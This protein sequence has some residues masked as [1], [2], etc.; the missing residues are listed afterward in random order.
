MPVDLCRAQLGYN[1]TFSFHCCCR[2][3]DI[4]TPVRWVGSI[5]CAAAG[6]VGALGGLIFGYGV[7]A[8]VE[9][10]AES[11]GDEER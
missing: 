11:G 3:K 6:S 2:N 10:W 1:S 8:W 4:I 9:V 7:D 5:E